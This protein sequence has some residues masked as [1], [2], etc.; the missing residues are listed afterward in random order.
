MQKTAPLLL[1]VGLLLVSCGGSSEIADEPA[2][3]TTTRTPTE[4]PISTL[5]PGYE[6]VPFT[7]AGKL[8]RLT[9]SDSGNSLV[10]INQLEEGQ[11]VVVSGT[12]AKV[13]GVEEFM[14]VGDRCFV[15]A[16][17][18]PTSV[19]YTVMAFYADIFF[20]VGDNVSYAG[21]SMTVERNVVERTEEMNRYDLCSGGIDRWVFTEKEDS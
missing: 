19:P 20:F 16:A 17:W 9:N 21:T 14:G 2:T 1:L 12:G 10:E 3:P 13:V 4:T 15:F 8:Y 18:G 7:G 5:E 6:F 11:W